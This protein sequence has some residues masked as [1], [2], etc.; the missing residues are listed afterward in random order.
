MDKPVGPSSFA[1]LSHV[2]GAPG[3][4]GRP[5]ACHGGTLD[6]FA[7]GLLLVLVGWATYLFEPLHRLPKTY[8]AEVAWG[9][10][11]DNGDPTGRVV[12][13]GPATAL[14]P[15][16]LDDALAPFLGWTDQVP[17]AT[18]ARK[19]DGEPAY[20]KVHRGEVVVLPPTPVYLHA[21]RWVDHALPGR[22]RLLLSC[23]GGFYVRALVRDLG[24]AVGVPAHLR[25]LRRTHIGPFAVTAAGAWARGDDAVRWLPSVGLDDASWARLRGTRQVAGLVAEPPRWSPADGFPA[26][27]APVV[28]RYRGAPV[29]LLDPVDGRARALWRPEGAPRRS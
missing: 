16:R 5:K 8:L 24:R 10:E 9:A 28:A 12:A 2:V 19:I 22:S 6:P 21:A 7:D 1:W 29:A 14:T 23:A 15:A 18:S 11:T 25:A 20:R 27:S 26:V 3:A 17:P 13:H 4:P